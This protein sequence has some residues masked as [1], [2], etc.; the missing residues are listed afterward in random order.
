MTTL[1]TAVSDLVEAERSTRKPRAVR[2]L[3]SR[4]ARATRTMWRRQERA[5]LARLARRRREF[6]PAKLAEAL[7]VD[8]MGDEV[9]AA[10]APFARVL[11]VELGRV[12]PRALVAGH[13]SAVTDVGMR[14]RLDLEDRRATAWLKGRGA[15]RVTGVDD[16][17]RA[18]IR[19]VLVQASE[20][21]WS[22]D[23]T[24]KVIS[25]RFAA[26]RTGVPQKH[27]RSRAELVSVT[28]VGDAYEHGRQLAIE[29]LADAGVDVEKSWLAL[30]DERVCEICGPN[31]RA[32]WIAS[33]RSFPS[34]HDRP[35]GH[36][37]CRCDMSLRPAG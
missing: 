32:G 2:P 33:K 31:A 21:G 35:L 20:H 11:E 26:F 36:P 18:Q 5:V 7:A 25:E 23:R 9:A 28:E 6:A 30:G 4:V 16:V 1:A 10:L 37:G 34:G 24:A 19:T 22:Y 27:L 29:D 15:A 13:R 8:D 12:W 3:E 17:T 14:M